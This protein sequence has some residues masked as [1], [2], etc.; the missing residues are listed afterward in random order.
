MNVVRIDF[1]AGGLWGGAKKEGENSTLCLDELF[2]SRSECVSG[3]V[4]KKKVRWFF[5]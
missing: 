3:V 4:E 1:W 2:Y 5:F